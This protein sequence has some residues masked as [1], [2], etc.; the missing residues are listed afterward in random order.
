MTDS[1]TRCHNPRRR[2]AFLIIICPTPIPM[3]LMRAVIGSEHENASLAVGAPWCGLETKS[4][5]GQQHARD[6]FHASFPRPLALTPAGQ[7]KSASASLAR[8]CTGTPY[9][10]GLYSGW[11][12]RRVGSI[13]ACQSGPNGMP[14]L[15][16]PRESTQSAFDEQ[17]AVFLYWAGKPCFQCHVSDS[18]LP[19]QSQIRRPFNGRRLNEA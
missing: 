16:R 18:I 11:E 19:V 4:A 13:S 10:A 14:L 9:E 5:I 3:I 8:R 15:F 7:Y 2:Q 6:P 1:G 12:L 17:M